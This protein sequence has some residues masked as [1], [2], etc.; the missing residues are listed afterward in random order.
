[1]TSKSDITA[2]PHSVILPLADERE[3]FS[4]QVKSLE[5]FTLEL[6]LY[7]TFGSKVISRAVILPSTFQDIRYHKGLIVPLLDHQIKT[8]G[9][10]AFEVSCIKPFEEA[11]L[12]IGG[13]V[14]T[15]WKSK[16]TPSTP[17]QDHAHQP[18][19]HRPLSVSTSSP[20][21]RPP[22]V[23]PS[24]TKE[25]ALVTASSLSGEYVEV[26]VQVTK[27]GVPVAYPEWQLPV[28]DLDVCVSEVTYAQFQLL[29]K[30]NGRAQPSWQ[31]SNATELHGIIAGAMVSFEQILRH[32]SPEFGLNVQLRYC[33]SNTGH[34]SLE[35][36]QYVDAILHEVYE[37]GKV[38][39][40]RKI[41]FSSFD[42]TVCTALNWKQPNCK[43]S[44]WFSPDSSRRILCI[45]LWYLA[46]SL[47]SRPGP[48]PIGPRIR[49]EVFEREGSG[50]LCKVDQP[51]RCDTGSYDPRGGPLAR[52]FR[53]GCRV[54]ARCVW[55]SDPC[56][57]A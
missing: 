38:N 12:E 48:S 27:D 43:L 53:Q 2:V 34:R 21:L 6:S 16:V 23:A 45:V 25:S 40:G 24:T 28:P 42:P 3:V 50:K 7:P 46:D 14:E 9:E 32:I 20:A 17:S 11:Q 57:F 33:K 51:P 54:A 52:R 55:R 41:I 47:H 19:S 5:R 31:F 30:R 35:V 29:A 15:Y 49:S 36:N 8:I 18:M 39:P 26:I 4:F 44:P 56:G 37:A 13:R 22:T 10:V 1:M